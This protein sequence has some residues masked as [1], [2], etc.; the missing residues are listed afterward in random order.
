MDWTNREI[1][2]IA[3]PAI[4]SNVTVPLLGLVDSAIS[5]H[6]GSAAYIGAVAVGSMLFNMMYWLLGFLRM[7]TS[8]MTS[9]A[10]GAGRMDEV[11]RLLHRAMLTGFGLGVGLIVL[12][13]PLRELGLLLM[14]PTDEVTELARTYFNICIWGAPAMLSLYSLNG[15]YIG[16]QDTRR[17]MIVSIVQNVI[18]IAASLLF[19]LGFGM[20]VEGIA[21]GTVVAQWSG[22]ALGVALLHSGYDVTLSVR[23]FKSSVSVQT[24]GGFFAVNRDIFLRTL[25]LV[26]VM[27]FFTSAGAR[28]GDTLLAVNTL[29]L[30]FSLIFSYVMDG[31]AFAAEAMCGKFYGAR[32][33]LHLRQ[34][35]RSVFVWGAA[36]VVVFTAVYVFG[37]EGFLR[38]L[39]DE[40]DVVQAS[41]DY[42]LWAVLLPLCGMAAFVWD[43]V[44]I[45]TTWAWQMLV[46]T[47]IAAFLFFGCYY[48]LLLLNVAG[49]NHVLW[50]AYL[51][52]LVMRGV[53][54]T[55]YYCFA[56][57]KLRIKN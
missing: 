8:G 57:R 53:V 2:R 5:G 32:D 10:L 29:L 13:W 54:Q 6:L 24:T 18:N 38:L 37:G 12:W 33:F 47:L 9:Q 50:L 36:L 19:V 41:T 14:Q 22:V 21:L 16:M 43:G 15:W 20:K 7:G 27:F 3:V 26:A 55:V 51:L 17:P 34:T 25:F 1:L 31:F 48:M 23:S 11:R 49:T 40:E 46:A 30:Q 28:Q 56:M 44:F 45:G 35:V 4:V 42:L 39:T 52:F